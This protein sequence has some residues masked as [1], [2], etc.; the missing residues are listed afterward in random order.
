MQR[1]TA[2]KKSGAAGPLPLSGNDPV[3]MLENDHIVI[4]GLLDE[5]TALD[6]AASRQQSFEALK[7]ALTIHNATEENIVYPAIAKVA[8]KPTESKQ[9]YHETA[10]ADTLVF[11]L[12]TLLKEG[13]EAAFTTKAKKLQKAVL[14]HIEEEETSAFPHLQKG[15]SEEQVE[16]L[17]Q[18][19]R[20]F[21]S[22]LQFRM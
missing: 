7:A 17:T 16:Q 5:L 14:A 8:H 18:S 15:A 10:E 13:D 22:A 1:T 21:R 4:K 11:E 9:L 19:V 12:D 2:T 6:D 3:E 20:E